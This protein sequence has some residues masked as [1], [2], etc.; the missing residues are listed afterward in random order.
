VADKEIIM[1][2]HLGKT[3]KLLIQ[4][5]RELKYGEIRVI[6]QDGKPTR[7]EEIRK[8]IVLG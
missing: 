4:M 2:E 8:S 3:E 1:K 5:I 7:V 6:V